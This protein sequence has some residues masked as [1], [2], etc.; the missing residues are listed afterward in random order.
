M[1]CYINCAVCR[2]VGRQV[3]TIFFFCEKLV[4]YYGTNNIVNCNKTWRESFNYLSI[5]YISACI[6]CYELFSFVLRSDPGFY[7][8]IRKRLFPL[9][10]RTH[11]SRAI[12]WKLFKLKKKYI[13]PW[14]IQVWPL[15]IW[16]SFYVYFMYLLFLF[17]HTQPFVS[18]ILT[19]KII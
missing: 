4:D 15:L 18:R 6:R 9:L 7:L 8:T 12:L 5:D 16:S 19:S 14:V 11:R 13:C 10:Y 3:L 2:T 1:S 17:K